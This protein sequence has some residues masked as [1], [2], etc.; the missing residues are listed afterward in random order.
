MI[1]SIK[2]GNKAEQKLMSVLDGLGIKSVKNDDPKTRSFYDVSAE[3]FGETKTFEVKYD[4]MSS[5]TGNFAIE[6]YN[7]KSNKDSGLMVTKADYWV[8]C[9]NE[10]E[11]IVIKICKVSELKDF[12]CQNNPCKDV[13]SCGD[14][15]SNMLIF[16][17]ER[18]LCLKDLSLE[19][20]RS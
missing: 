4:V 12:C 1:K 2:I 17:K 9:F 3:I 7:P 18:I 20:F 15:N 14:N 10:G 19:F 13:K 8:H 6:Y 11:E 16:K 5:K